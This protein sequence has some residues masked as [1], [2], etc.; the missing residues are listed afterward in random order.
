MENDGGASRE[1]ADAAVVLAFP[2]ELRHARQ[3]VI[4]DAGVGATIVAGG[5]TQK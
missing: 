5:V 1:D 4:A 3:F 2:D